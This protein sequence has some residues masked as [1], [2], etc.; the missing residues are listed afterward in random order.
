MRFPSGYN[1]RDEYL[2]DPA[3]LTQVEKI[4]E[5]VLG[6]ACS[7]QQEVAD[8]GVATVRTDAPTPRRPRGDFG[9]I[10]LVGKAMELLEARVVAED[11]EFG[12]QPVA[13]ERAPETESEED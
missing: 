7:L 3:R 11:P 5:S 8:N 2:L 6:R 10:P 12:A 9:A 1:H 13:P 4:L